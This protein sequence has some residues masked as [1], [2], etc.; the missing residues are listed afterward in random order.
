MDQPVKNRGRRK[1]F[2]CL[3]PVVADDEPGYETVSSQPYSDDEC[4]RRKRS[5]IRVHRS[6]SGALKDVFSKTSLV[7]KIRSKKSKQEKPCRS[8]SDL[9]SK[10][11][12]S[13][14]YVK[15]NSSLKNFSDPE[16]IF[17]TDSNRF[18]LFSSSNSSTT[19][20]SSR[21]SSISSRSESERIGRS[22]SLNSKQMN[23]INNK[24]QYLNTM[25]KDLSWSKCDLN[26]TRSGMC[27]FVACLG[28]L[29]VWGK[30]FAIMI[31]TSTWLFFAPGRRVKRMESIVC[32][33]FDSEEYKKKVI[34]EGLLER[35]RRPRVL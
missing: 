22:T 27:I 7:K 16:E 2:K 14:T 8:S 23:L 21:S 32:E 12:N 28:A 19:T 17:R 18:S 6:L 1:F 34:M 11:E 13:I 9:S 5:N 20:P 3:R 24:P 33:R 26:I 10:S 35:N 15:K 29:V 30:V 25:K 4:G 31:C